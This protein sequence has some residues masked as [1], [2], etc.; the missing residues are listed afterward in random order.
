MLQ[1]TNSIIRSIYK[2]NDTID[3]KRSQKV[4]SE[5]RNDLNKLMV[6]LYSKE[7]TYVRCIKPNETKSSGKSFKLQK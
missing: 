3:M 4:A 7:P 5:F 2:P 1:S 6:I